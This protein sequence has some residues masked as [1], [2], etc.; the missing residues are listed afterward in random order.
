MTKISSLTFALLIITAFGLQSASAQFRIPDIPR[1][2]KPK[3]ELPKQEQPQTSNEQANGSSSTSGGDDNSEAARLRNAQNEVMQVKPSNVGKIYFSNRPFGA[4]NDGSKTSFASGEYIYGRLETSGG[5]LREVLKFSSITTANPEHRLN[6]NLYLYY[7]SKDIGGAIQEVVKDV[8]NSPFT[9]LTEGDLDKT[10]WNF[11]VLPEP[12]K[13]ATRMYTYVR[14]LELE[15]QNGPYALY[16]YLKEQAAEQ[17]Y[18]LRIELQKET[19]NFRGEVESQDK[20]PVVEG[21]A[22]MDFRGTDFARIKADGDQMEANR[23]G[24]YKT[25]KAQ[26]DSAELANEPLPNEWTLKSNLPLPGLTEASVK[27]MFLHDHPYWV[28]KQIVKLYSGPAPSRGFTVVP[29]ELG[30]PKYR[31]VSQRFTVFVKVVGEDKCFYQ[32]LTP[33]QAYSGAGTFGDFYALLE[34]RVNISCTKIGVN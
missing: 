32:R 33:A 28:Q 30:I 31:Y 13:A 25:A 18:T 24:R 27:A 16:R 10:Y 9:V 2:K 4:I 19:K 23:L 26:S 29:N 22:T 12:S 8:S 3:S 21:R 6:Y 34:P 7:I 14:M 20:W 15:S 11:D 5:T 1:I 17:T